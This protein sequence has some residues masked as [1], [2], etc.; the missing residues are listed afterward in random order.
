MKE[1]RD[2]LQ[3]LRDKNLPMFIPE[4]CHKTY[5]IQW[6]DKGVDPASVREHKKYIDQLC[7]D[8][9]RTLTGMITHG[10]K[11]R[12][13]S[14]TDTELFQEVVQHVSFCQQKCSAFHGREAILKTIH[15]YVTGD[16]VSPLTVFGVSGSGKTSVVAMAA[17]QA[18]ETLDEGALVVRFIGT[19]PDSSSVCSLLRSVTSQVWTIYGH[20]VH[21]LPT[22]VKELSGMFHQALQ[23]AHVSKPLVVLLDSLDQLDNSDNGRQL[24]WLPTHLP[25]HVRLVVSTLPESQHECLQR[26]QAMVPSKGFFVQV[27]K[28][29][30]GDATGILDKWLETAQRKLTTGQR[31]VIN[32]AFHQCPLPLFLKLAFD[33][34]HRWRSFTPVCETVLES[35]VRGCIKMLFLKLERAHGRMFVSRALGYLTISRRGLTESELE[36]I[37]SCDDDVLNDVYMYWTPPIRRL[38][39]LLLVRLK[40]EFNQYLVDKG[41]DGVRVFFW[42]H[43]QFIEAAYERYCSDD[44]DQ[45]KM[46]GALGDF[47]SGVWAHGTQKPY[48]DEHG[49]DRKADR[50]VTAQQLRFGES[51]NLR[52]L[53]NLAFHRLRAGQ[54]ALLKQ[55]CLCNFSFMQAKLVALGLR[56][57]LEDFLDARNLFDEDNAISTIGEALQLSQGALIKYPY[58]LPS[59]LR[60]RIKEDKELRPFLQQCDDSPTGY[61]VANKP[62]LTRPGGQLVHCLAGHKGDITG[63]AITCNGEYAL[64]CSRDKTLKIWDVYGGKLYRSIDNVGEDPDTIRLCLNDHLALVN[65]DG[66]IQAYEIS[67]GNRKYVIKVEDMK[68]QFCCAG[69]GETTVAV[70]TLSTVQLYRAN[71]GQLIQ[72]VKCPYVGGDITMGEEGPS[73]G[74]G[75]YLVTVDTE[76]RHLFVFN[77]QTATFTMIKDVFS[78]SEN[79]GGE[80]REE[81]T[82]VDALALI[83]DGRTIV[84]SNM[85]SNDLHLLDSATLKQKRVL[86][87]SQRDI[88]EK[89]HV[90]PDC[91]YVYFA[92]FN[93]VVAWDVRSEDRHAILEHHT[94]YHDVATADMELVVTTGEDHVVK[95]WDISR[96]ATS[97]AR[98]DGFTISRFAVLDNPRYVVLF[99][100]YDVSRRF[101]NVYDLVTCSYV[102]Q[103]QVNADIKDLVVLDN[104]RVMVRVGRKLK[105]VDFSKMAVTVT[106]QGQ[107]PLGSYKDFCVV[108]QRKEVVSVTRGRSHIKVYK[109]ATGK[110]S[111]VIKSEDGH[112]LICVLANKSGTTLL[113]ETEEGTYLVFDL[114]IQRFRYKFDPVTLNFK[115]TYTDGACVTEDGR[116]FIFNAEMMTEDD[117][118]PS[119]IYIWNINKRE[120]EHELTDAGAYEMF[121]ET[122]DIYYN[123]SVDSFEFLP[124][125]SILANL[126]DGRMRLFDTISGN[127]TMTLPGHASARMC[128]P[129]VGP[130]VLTRGTLVEDRT[131]RL[132]DRKTFQSVATFTPDFNLAELFLTSDGHHCVGYFPNYPDPV[133]WTLRDTN[134]QKQQKGYKPLS[135]FISIYGDKASVI[136]AH[137]ETAK[138]NG[139]DPADPDTDVDETEDDVIDE[140][141]ADFDED[142]F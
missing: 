112:R 92:S 100:A 110:V 123:T 141:D 23:L 125:S 117:S 18:S 74:S 60:G 42:Y 10:I 102:R 26:M 136:V 127:M 45:K 37:L 13:S 88:L 8:F 130:Y 97:E 56:Q 30:D 66:E 34:A 49:T 48:T 89:F 57:V 52:L 58:E 59:Q 68:V 137:L 70:F 61:L 119:K 19:T 65:P 64:T 124:P 50:H 140:D 40:A 44:S 77:V 22:D 111:H 122:G 115:E 29:P 71:D 3:E 63:L 69:P 133:L 20:E 72:E 16:S 93:N 135:A 36:D 131:F 35:T 15:K 67:T 7:E 126:N 94:R 43:R 25:P 54:V 121:L 81:M 85:F 104:H 51:Y 86:K 4:K 142:W 107:L 24:T 82:T 76:Q 99:G 32:A 87:G 78:A 75:N 101:L 105:I 129:E 106:F 2:L 47:F 6:L 21:D 38:P 138:D 128:V 80:V 17:K 11:T 118:A 84:V 27:P 134:A 116:F 73:A 28:L 108:K 103:M 41:A 62:I 53:N 55:Q 91:R 79:D 12:A 39:P 96:E 83:D 46:H 90:T 113:A 120:V 1:A 33:E 98:D 114:N 5:S 9:E 14:D 132:L 139:D 31:G 95:V 109:T